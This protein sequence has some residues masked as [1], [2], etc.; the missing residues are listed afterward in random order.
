MIF[1][2]MILFYFLIKNHFSFYGKNPICI[3]TIG[4]KKITL[5]IK[6]LTKLYR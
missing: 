5:V 6:D 4:K 1:L 3:D 2:D